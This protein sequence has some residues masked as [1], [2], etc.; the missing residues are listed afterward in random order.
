MEAKFAEINNT[1]KMVLQWREFPFLL[2]FS[3]TFM[4][5][6]HGIVR[7]S[8]CIQRSANNFLIRTHVHLLPKLLILFNC[9]RLLMANYF[10]EMSVK[11]ELQRDDSEKAVGLALRSMYAWDSFAFFDIFVKN[12]PIVFL[13]KDCFSQY[14]T[15]FET[16]FLA[17]NKKGIASGYNWFEIQ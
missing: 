7:T 6:L 2:L 4:I 9:R 11:E 8:T 3:G 1:F 5:F 15:E 16:F 14:Q 13:P 10:A 17:F 12:S